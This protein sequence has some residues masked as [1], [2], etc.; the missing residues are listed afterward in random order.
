[1]AERF[2]DPTFEKIGKLTVEA[3]AVWKAYFEMEESRER[4]QQCQRTPQ[5][6]SMPTR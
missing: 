1:M 4:Q 6:P 2:A 5:P 3:W